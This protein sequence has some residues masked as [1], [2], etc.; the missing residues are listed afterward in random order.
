MTA[1][2]PS[3]DSAKMPSK[4]FFIVSVSTNVP[5]TMD[6][7]MTTASAVRR[8]RTLRPARP[9]SATLIIGT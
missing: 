1:S 3:Y 4:A 7:P 6:T 9:L 2:V 8:A 5:L